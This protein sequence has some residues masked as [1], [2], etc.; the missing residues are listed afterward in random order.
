MQLVWAMRVKEKWCTLDDYQS[1]IRSSPLLVLV[2]LSGGFADLYPMIIVSG[3]A[4][5]NIVIPSQQE[6]LWRPWHEE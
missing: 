6:A 4:G 1:L 5:T 3:G 2:D